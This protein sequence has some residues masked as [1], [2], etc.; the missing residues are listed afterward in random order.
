M[1]KSNLGSKIVLLGLAFAAASLLAAA[2]CAPRASEPEADE[3]VAEPIVADFAW[4]SDADCAM[5]H[6][7]EAASMDDAACQAEIHQQNGASCAT[8]HDDAAA[9]EAVHEGATPSSKMPQRLAKTSVAE[10]VCLGCHE[11]L[12]ELA[13][14]TSESAAL[15]DAEGTA[16]NPH[17]LPASDD[18]DVI[19]CADCHRMHEAGERGEVAKKTCLACHHEDVF[20]CGTCHEEQ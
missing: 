20:E 17:A 1:G 9:L 8:C 3:P 6:A 12:E 15:V 18:H 10:S 16:V 19:A 11:G 4:T 5:C 2:G 7:A 14:K 13:A